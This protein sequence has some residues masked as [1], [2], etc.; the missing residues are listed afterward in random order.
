[1]FKSI[2]FK[3]IKKW[4]INIKTAAGEEITKEIAETDGAEN[5]HIIINNNCARKATAGGV[6]FIARNKLFIGSTNGR[7]FW[8]EMDATK[9]RW[10]IF[11]VPVAAA[12]AAAISLHSCA[13]HYY[14]WFQGDRSPSLIFSAVS[15]IL[16]EFPSKTINV[17]FRMV[18]VIQRNFTSGYE[19]FLRIPSRF[20]KAKMK[21]NPREKLM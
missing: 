3:F 13:L 18:P 16:M 5:K 9:Q 2:L 12:G 4:K 11:H 17:T 19:I 15:V 20:P 10:E 8:W 1:M 14:L 7:H 21:I 6:N